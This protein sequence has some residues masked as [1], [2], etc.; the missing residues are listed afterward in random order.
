MRAA[1]FHRILIRG[2]TVERLLVISIGAENEQAS[3]V[4]LEI[5]GGR[6]K[7]KER[8][9]KGSFPTGCE[10]QQSA[11]CGYLFSVVKFNN[12]P[13]SRDQVTLDWGTL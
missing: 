1:L 12:F 8:V 3:V 11:K 6:E 9:G 4:Q 13:L 10:A 7:E 2:G 5:S